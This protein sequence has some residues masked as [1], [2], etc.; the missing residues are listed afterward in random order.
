MIKG[1]DDDGCLTLTAEWESAG[2]F[3]GAVDNLKQELSTFPV[4]FD[5]WQARV[6]YEY[7]DDVPGEDGSIVEFCILNGVLSGF[8]ESRVTMV[9]A[10]PWCTFDLKEEQC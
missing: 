1:R 10:T 7:L 9:D 8:K 6:H 5:K 4:P 3:F 2:Y